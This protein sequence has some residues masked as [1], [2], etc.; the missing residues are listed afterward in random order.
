VT[1]FEELGDGLADI[2][3]IIGDHFPRILGALVLLVIGWWLAR[4]L[5]SLIDRPSI[6]TLLD[7]VYVG[8][9]LREAGY[10]APQLLAALL[11]GLVMLA[12]LTLAAELTNVREIEET[13][14]VLTRFLPRLV[15][16]VV[17]LAL[18]VAFGRWFSRLLDPYAEARSFPWLPVIARWLFYIIGGRGALSLAGFGDETGLLIVGV[19]TSI[20]V[21]FTIAW[22]VGGIARARTWWEA[23]QLRAE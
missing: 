15:G 18:A 8:Q 19:A 12:A 4:L 11:S 1:F 21:I 17:I 2:G 22:G 20:L 13:M 6:G 23:R 16:A 10:E 14:T 7:R 5:R 9:P 3:T